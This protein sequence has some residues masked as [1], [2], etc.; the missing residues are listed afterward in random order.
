M[1]KNLKLSPPWNTFVNELKLLFAEDPDVTVKYE[2]GS[3]EVILYVEGAQ[4]ADALTQIMPDQ[5]IYGNV[6]INVKVVP[7]NKPNTF[8]PNL[9]KLAFD[10]NPIV[11]RFIS[12]PFPG[13]AMNY[14]E[15]RK[16][17]VQFYND[18]LSDPHGNKST[19]YEDIAKDVFGDCNVFFCTNNND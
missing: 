3:D 18:E 7:A 16:Q 17:V 12:I 14:L 6:V 13:S 9:F 1:A 4:K 2:D 19:L 15:F 10:G 11:T 8:E 5:R